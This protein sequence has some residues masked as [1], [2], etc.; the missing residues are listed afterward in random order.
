[1]RRLAEYFLLIGG[2]HINLSAFNELSPSSEV[3]E[4]AFWYL[5]REW[6]MRLAAP[7]AKTNFE[8]A[9]RI[10]PSSCFSNAFYF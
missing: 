5:N 9:A 1:M 3:V 8:K 4:V 10:R 7:D 6:N 2:T